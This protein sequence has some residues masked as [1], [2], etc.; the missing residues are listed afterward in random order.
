VSKR[1]KLAI[2]ALPPGVDAHAFTKLNRVSSR[3]RWTAS[4]LSNA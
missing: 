2:L 1:R 4:A 3:S